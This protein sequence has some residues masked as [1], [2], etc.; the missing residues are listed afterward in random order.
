MIKRLSIFS[1]LSVTGYFSFITPQKRKDI[2]GFSKSLINSW[3]A[4]II[5]AQSIYDY[6][7]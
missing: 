6:T 4:G 7:Y 1:V 2:D 5:L 3:R